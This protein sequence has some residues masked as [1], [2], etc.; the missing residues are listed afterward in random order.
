MNLA[1]TLAFRNKSNYPQRILANNLRNTMSTISLR[2]PESIH[3][4]VKEIAKRERISINQLISTALAEKL[5]ALM[6]QEYLEERAKRG[7]RKRFDK[8]ISKIKDRA[9][10]PHDKLE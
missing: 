7:S 2:L 6:T 3:K 10:Q 8:A 1:K 4:R 9:P 5:S